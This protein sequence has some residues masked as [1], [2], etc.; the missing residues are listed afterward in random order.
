MEKALLREVP[1][2]SDLSEEEMRSISEITVT[3]K[4]PKNAVIL[5]ADEEGD[6]MFVI[7][8]GRV[9]VSLLGEDGS[10]VILSLLGIGQFFGEMSLLDGKPRS[11]TV[12][13]IEDSEVILLRRPDFLR[14]LERIPRIAVK[15]LSFLTGRLR[16][17]DQQI[18]NLALRNVSGRVAATLIQLAEEQGTE[19]DEGIV[20]TDRPTHQDLG[21]MAGTTRETVSRVLKRFEREGYIASRGRDLIIL[22]ERD[23]RQDFL[24]S[25]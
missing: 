14:S 7:S 25:A 11:A 4:Y 1:L 24:C 23:L 20:I 15:L 16:K 9:K 2:F 13:A 17:A 10:E 19:T 8:R 12:T 21:N 6:T 22:G 5:M 18:E 3:R